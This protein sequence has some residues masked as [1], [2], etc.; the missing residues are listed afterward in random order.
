MT[1][2]STVNNKAT[3]TQD[4]AVAAHTRALDVTIDEESC[5]RQWAAVPGIRRHWKGSKWAV[6]R[7]TST[8]SGRGHRY[9]PNGRPSF[10]TS[11]LAMT[12]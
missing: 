6:G 11:S 5:L 12:V 10:L 8:R 3:R 2:Q 1:R 9:P 4:M 7:N